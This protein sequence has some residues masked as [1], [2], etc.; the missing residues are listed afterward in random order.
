MSETATIKKFNTL[1]EKLLN[2]HDIADLDIKDVHAV[3]RMWIP[4]INLRD[5]VDVSANRIFGAHESD[6][7]TES[8]ALAVGNS[9]SEAHGN[10]EEAIEAL[11]K[12]TSVAFGATKC[13]RIAV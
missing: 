12:Q 3:A 6:V 4:A 2:T 1:V 7:L 10:F 11:N 9:L 5:V 13:S 8:F